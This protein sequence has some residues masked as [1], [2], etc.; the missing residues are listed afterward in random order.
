V[1]VPEEAAAGLAKVSV[2]MVDWPG[3]QVRPA[4]VEVPIEE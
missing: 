4:T 2:R 1:W 3:Q